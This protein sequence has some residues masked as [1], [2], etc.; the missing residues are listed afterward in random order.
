MA[1]QRARAA[2]CDPA[3]RPAGDRRP[4]RGGRP[5][6]AEGQRSQTGVGGGA[7]PCRHRVRTGAC[8]R[9]DRTGRGGAGT[10]PPG[11]VPA[12]GPLRHQTSMSDCQ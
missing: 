12:H 6:P 7:G 9:R 5:Q 1:G 10:Q 2:Q 8:R 3:R 4:H 11:A